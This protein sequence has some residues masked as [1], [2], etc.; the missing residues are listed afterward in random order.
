MAFE[1]HVEADSG[2][3]D[4]VA[5]VDVDGLVAFDFAH[6]VVEVAGLR[7]KDDLFDE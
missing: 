2:H 3:V 1:I 6:G 5:E 7:L 4:R